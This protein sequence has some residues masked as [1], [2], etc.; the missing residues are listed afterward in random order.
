MERFQIDKP[1]SEKWEDMAG[2]LAIRNCSKCHYN[3][4]NFE[5]MSDE[6]IKKALHN[7]ER[8]CARLF[9]RPDG[10]HM[11]KSCREKSKRYKILKWIGIAALMPISLALFRSDSYENSIDKL[12]NVPLLGEIVN[13]LHPRPIPQVN[14]GQVMAIPQKN[15]ND[16]TKE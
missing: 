8:I 6:E 15:Q 12:R 9:V 13:K 5:V 7:G 16:I 11:T 10:K 4:Y 14:V 2:G 1:C 3:V